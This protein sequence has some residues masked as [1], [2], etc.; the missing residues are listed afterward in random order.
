MTTRR[1]ARPPRRQAGIDVPTE[2][3][4]PD[5]PASSPKQI[6]CHGDTVAPTQRQLQFRNLTDDPRLNLRLAGI[7][8]PTQGT[9]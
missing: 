9:G 4:Q 8:T 3:R 6:C 7:P 1:L 2:W 5:P